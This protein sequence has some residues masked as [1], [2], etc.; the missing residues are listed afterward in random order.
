MYPHARMHFCVTM[1]VK[2][3]ESFMWGLGVVENY[4]FEWLCVCWRKER[5]VEIIEWMKNGFVA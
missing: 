1:R 4:K 3:R 5:L 2:E